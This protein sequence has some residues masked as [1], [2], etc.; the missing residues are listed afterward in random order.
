MKLTA[1]EPSL[2]YARTNDVGNNEYDYIT[3]A[4]WSSMFLWSVM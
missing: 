4:K 1:M 2:V 3:K